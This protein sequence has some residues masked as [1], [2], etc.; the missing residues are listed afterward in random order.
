[1]I[2]GA[3]RA[4][5]KALKEHVDDKPSMIPLDTIDNSSTSNQVVQH[6]A[7]TQFLGTTSGHETTCPNDSLHTNARMLGIFDNANGN[8]EIG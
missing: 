6:L 5:C 3:E 2:A 8:L 1:M 4:I 7:P